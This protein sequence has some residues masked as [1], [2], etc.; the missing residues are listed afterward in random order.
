MS[1]FIERARASARLQQ[2]ATKVRALRNRWVDQPLIQVERARRQFKA[3]PVEVLYLGDSSANTWTTEDSD[4]RSI[5]ELVA[6]RVGGTVASIVS[7]GLSAD[8]FAEIVRILGT[9]NERPRAVMVTV[10]IRTHLMTHVAHHPQFG[11]QR[12]VAA[13]RGVTTARRPIRAFGRGGVR[14]TPRERG[15]FLAMPIDTRWGGVITVGEF[16]D[17]LAGLGAPPWPQEVE[18]MRYNYFHGELLPADLPEFKAFR[19]LARELAAYGVPVIPFW[20]APPLEHGEQLFPGEFES[21]VRQQLE[22][23][24]AALRESDPTFPEFIDPQLTDA[25]YEDSRLANE[26]YRLSG[27]SKIADAIVARLPPHPTDP[28]NQP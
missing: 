22:Q 3:G 21:H 27:R 13:M 17:K 14:D 6:E 23:V 7:P 26:H 4:R 11:Y 9:L 19:D 16:R 18:R 10:T 15:A 24:K 8:A 2:Q 25:D 20:N 1:R 28:R 5:P 12:S